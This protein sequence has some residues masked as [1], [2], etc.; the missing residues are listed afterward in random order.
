MN[1]S[2]GFPANH[3]GKLL[4]H[5]Y[6]PRCRTD[7]NIPPAHETLPRLIVHAIAPFVPPLVGLG[8]DIQAETVQ[9][10][11]RDEAARGSGLPKS[12]SCFWSPRLSV[13]FSRQV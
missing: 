13:L 5:A 8:D 4:Q 10:P 1:G 12:F 2:C 9:S 6:Y 11:H 3:A 7:Q